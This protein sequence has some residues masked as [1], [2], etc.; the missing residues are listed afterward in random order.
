MARDR[1]RG[2]F[3]VRW[4][5]VVAT[6]VRGAGGRVFKFQNWPLVD[7]EFRL[8]IQPILKFERPTPKPA[9]AW[10]G[11]VTVSRVLANVATSLQRRP[12]R[13]NSLA[14]ALCHAGSP[15]GCRSLRRTP[16][17]LRHESASARRT[18]RRTRFAGRVAGSKASSGGRW[19]SRANARVFHPCDAAARFK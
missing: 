11:W 17:C 4:A 19:P 1:R 10:A 12:C 2:L 6:F 9:G 15:G 3:R 13:L 18:Y 8:S 16:A 14:G 7:C 5:P